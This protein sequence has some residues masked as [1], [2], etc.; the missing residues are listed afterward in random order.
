MWKKSRESVKIAKT[1]AELLM[2]IW[3]DKEFITEI[4]NELDGDQEKAEELI[5]CIQENNFKVPSQI[6]SALE[7]ITCKD[8][9]QKF[10]KLAIEKIK[11][12]HEQE[13]MLHEAVHTEK[14]IMVCEW[15][16]SEDEEKQFQTAEVGQAVQ[17]KNPPI[18]ILLQDID[19][20][21]IIIPIFTSEL[22]L[23]SNYRNEHYSI[24]KVG[25][26]YVRRFYNK[27]EETMGKAVVLLDM[28]GTFGLDVT[29]EIR[30]RKS[31]E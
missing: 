6:Y 2:E 14:I 23:Q 4:L 8:F 17:V 12:Y 30:G 18:P 21:E 19:S 28:D 27:V 20:E 3:Q 10:D 11:A 13:N 1:L 25:W 24:Q 7:I 31:D 29:D 15:N 16:L 5:K 9:C 22:E 26:T